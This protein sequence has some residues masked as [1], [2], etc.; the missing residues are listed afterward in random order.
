MNAGRTSLK[1]AFRR[2]PSSLPSDMFHAILAYSSLVSASKS[3][4]KPERSLVDLD[5]N[6]RNASHFVILIL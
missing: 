5:E 3:T 6:I 2:A 1:K 4:G